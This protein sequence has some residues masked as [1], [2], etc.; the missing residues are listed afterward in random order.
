MLR[1]QWLFPAILVFLLKGAAMAQ[2]S[3]PEVGSML[4]EVTVFNEQGNELSTKTLRGNYT[5]LVFGCL[6]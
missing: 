2:F 5:I 6:T 3:L 4:P 1:N